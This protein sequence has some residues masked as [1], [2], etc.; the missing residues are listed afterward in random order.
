MVDFYD[1]SSCIIYFYGL[2]TYYSVGVVIRCRKGGVLVINVLKNKNEWINIFI[3]P[4]VVTQ[5]F[6]EKASSFFFFL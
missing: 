6:R 3:F 4:N 2:Y 1:H 5:N